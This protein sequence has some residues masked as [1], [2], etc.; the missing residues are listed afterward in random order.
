V[1]PTRRALL[2]DILQL[3][4]RVEGEFSNTRS[5]DP[6]EF[7]VGQTNQFSVW[8]C[9]ENDLP[10]ISLIRCFKMCKVGSPGGLS[11]ATLHTWGTL[12]HI[13]SPVIGS[14]HPA[15]WFRPT[16]SVRKFME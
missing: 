9:I 2:Q 10:A 4:L 12:L 3:M 7:L 14:Q 5:H 11:A 16:F 15:A 6:L 13:L 8:A 1:R